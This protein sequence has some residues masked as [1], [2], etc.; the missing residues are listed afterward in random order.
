MADGRWQMADVGWQTA[1]F[2]FFAPSRPRD[3]AFAFISA[4]WETGNQKT[5]RIVSE[6]PQGI[7][8]SKNLEGIG[9]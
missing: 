4:G 1:P 7:Y 8:A 3:L 5:Q 2:G 9:Q 6:Q